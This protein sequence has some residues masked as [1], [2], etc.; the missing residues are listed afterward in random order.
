METAFLM[1]EIANRSDPYLSNYNIVSRV[2]GRQNLAEIT[3]DH[4]RGLRE[5]LQLANECKVHDCIALP[6]LAHTAA[7]SSSFHLPVALVAGFALFQA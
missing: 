5:A 2:L 4:N 3:V 7:F 1:H 6:A